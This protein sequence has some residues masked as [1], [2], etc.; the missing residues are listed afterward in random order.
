MRPENVG[1]RLSLF[2]RG[3]VKSSSSAELREEVPEPS[4]FASTGQLLA[5]RQTRTKY[6]CLIRRKSGLHWWGRTAAGRLMGKRMRTGR[7]Q[8]REII[9]HPRL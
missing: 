5:S 8:Q 9:A 2:R 1:D 6:T 3:R 4:S 7:V